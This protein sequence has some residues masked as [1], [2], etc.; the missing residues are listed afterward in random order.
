MRKQILII[1]GPQSGKTTI[2]KSILSLTKES[3]IMEENDSF[4]RTNEPFSDFRIIIGCEFNSWEAL[5]GVLEN[6][7]LKNQEI[8]MTI[9]REVVPSHWTAIENWITVINLPDP[10]TSKKQ[11]EDVLVK[12]RELYAFE[13][14]TIAEKT[15]ES[16]SPHDYEKTIKAISERAE[17]GHYSYYQPDKIHWM[18]IEKLRLKGF[19]VEENEINERNIYII[20]W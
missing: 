9:P 14:R 20:S 18:T 2:L 19:T 4:F 5:C 7:I 13:L 1:G 16:T 15:I 12:K 10:A 11:S 6:C 8:V 17:K 3:V